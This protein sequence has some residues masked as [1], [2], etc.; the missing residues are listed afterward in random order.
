MLDALDERLLL[1]IKLDQQIA[2]CVSW[3]II[4]S[5][6][7]AEVLTSANRALQ[8]FSISALQLVSF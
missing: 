7:F 5:Q 6:R 2:Q 4:W 8:H 1:L 3:Q